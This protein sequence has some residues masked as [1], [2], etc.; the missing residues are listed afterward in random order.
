MV[1]ASNL[2]A[3]FVTPEMRQLI[4]EAREDGVD[5]AGFQD[6][7]DAHKLNRVR[8]TYCICRAFD[9]GFAEAK[10]IQ[11]IRDYGSTKP[12]ADAIIQAIDEIDSEPSD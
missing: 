1:D 3:E 5:L 11:I 12:W 10:E 6:R 8:R 7:M 9:L 4:A 2:N